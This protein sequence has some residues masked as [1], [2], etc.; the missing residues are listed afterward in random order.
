MIA[1]KFKIYVLKCQQNKFYVGRSSAINLEHRI[2]QHF[3]QKSTAAAWTKLYRPI[4]LVTAI[5]STNIFDEDYYTKE[6]MM[7]HRVE[8]VRGGSYTHIQ[9][10]PWQITALKHEF[11]T[12][13]NRCF[14]CGTGGHFAIN[15]CHNKKKESYLFLQF[16]Q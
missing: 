7:L 14:R 6:L 12:A 15:C 2:E 10:L 8:N 3:S 1:N 11:A 13:L 5:N 9:L 4:E 16:I